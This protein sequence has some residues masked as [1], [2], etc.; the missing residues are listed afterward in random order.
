[1]RDSFDHRGSEEPNDERSSLPGKGIESVGKGLGIGEEE[2]EFQTRS[3]SDDSM[4]SETPGPERMPQTASAMSLPFTQDPT[5]GP[6]P[7]LVGEGHLGTNDWRCDFPG[8]GRCFQK[9]HD[10]K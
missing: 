3:Y 7:A 4:I 2:E 1:M 6:A 8:C 5:M 9:R 10:L